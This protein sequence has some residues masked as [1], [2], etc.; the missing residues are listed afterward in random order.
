MDL[1]ETIKYVRKR[2]QVYTRF[3]RLFDE[4]CIEMLPRFNYYEVFFFRY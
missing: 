2:V 3:V 1:I 4:R